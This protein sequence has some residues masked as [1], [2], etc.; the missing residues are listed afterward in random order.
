V[1]QLN[2]VGLLPLF[3]IRVK[4]WRQEYNF[5]LTNNQVISKQ[6]ENNAIETLDDN[7]KVNTSQWL[8]LFKYVKVFK[9]GHSL[10][11]KPKPDL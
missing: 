5:H 7:N 6:F 4:M 1:D 10:L 9:Q 11:Y 2:L 8:C 3:T